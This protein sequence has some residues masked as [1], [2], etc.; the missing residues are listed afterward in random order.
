MKPASF[1][2]VVLNSYHP[3][4]TLDWYCDVLDGH[5]VYDSPVACFMTYDNEHHRVGASML[6]GGP[7]AAH[8]ASTAKGPGMQHLAY[9]FRT[10]SD[11]LAHYTELKAKGNKPVVTI[12]HG[13]TVSFYYKDP[14]GN[15]LEFFVDR[16]ATKQ[17]STDF[18]STPSFQAN[19]AGI[20]VDPEKM[21]AQLEAGESEESVMHYDTELDVDVEGTVA[22]VLQHLAK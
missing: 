1:S 21:I 18:M 17:E 11:L 2:H 8:G 7:A 9:N 5:I 15:N 3:R 19:P 22:H 16:F 20:L 10:I 6:P 12:N 14:D 4:E 13:P